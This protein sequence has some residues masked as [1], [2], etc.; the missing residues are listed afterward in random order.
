MPSD[1]ISTRK[2]GKEY[3]ISFVGYEE[4]NRLVKSANSQLV[5]YYEFP[6]EAGQITIVDNLASFDALIN[7]IK[8]VFLSYLLFKRN[9]SINILPR[10]LMC[11]IN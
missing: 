3:D 9:F 11:R 7:R 6:L 2:D 8:Q 5:A 1:E 4:E 10:W